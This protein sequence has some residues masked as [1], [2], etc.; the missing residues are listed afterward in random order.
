MFINKTQ[1]TKRNLRHR[2][3]LHSNKFFWLV[4]STFSFSCINIF[5]WWGGGGVNE[6]LPYILRGEKNICISVSE[7]WNFNAVNTP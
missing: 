1:Q 4:L 2:Q 5:L 7:Y 6:S 3:N